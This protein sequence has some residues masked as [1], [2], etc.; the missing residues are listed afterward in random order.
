MGRF[1]MLLEDCEFTQVVLACATASH[2]ALRMVT[3]LDLSSVG[4][5]EWQ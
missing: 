5:T 1:T 2:D 4:S 3:V